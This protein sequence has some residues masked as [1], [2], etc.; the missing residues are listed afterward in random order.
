ML[1][2]KLPDR[3]PGDPNRNSSVPRLRSSSEPENRGPKVAG[4]VPIAQ[5][6]GCP[7]P[8]LFPLP[9]WAPTYTAE[10]L[11]QVAFPVLLRATVQP[12]RPIQQD[13]SLERVGG[14]DSSSPWYLGSGHGLEVPTEA[15]S[16]PGGSAMPES[17]AQRSIGWVVPSPAACGETALFLLTTSSSSL[18]PSPSFPRP[19]SQATRQTARTR[20]ASP[21]CSSLWPLLALSYPALPCTREWKIRAQSSANP[22][23]ST[24][25][26]HP[27]LRPKGNLAT[28]KL[29]RVG[30]PASPC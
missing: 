19:P 1:H 20:T 17:Q 22:A 5:R 9:P 7:T 18:P 10:L 2:P 27:C 16:L 24:Y 14:R 21:C 28:S 26:V 23:Q 3:L 6:G 30:Q 13:L 11:V 29:G 12:A 25:G 4:R 8:R 15:P